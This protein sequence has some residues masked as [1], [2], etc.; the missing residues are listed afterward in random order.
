MR[1]PLAILFA[2]LLAACS[3]GDGDAPPPAGAASAAASE[4]SERSCGEPAQQQY[5]EA[6]AGAKLEARY[7]EL[8]VLILGRAGDGERTFILLDDDWQ[9]YLRQGVRDLLASVARLEGLAPVAGAEGVDAQVR[10][11]VGRT[12]ELAVFLGGGDE[13]L[14]GDRLTEAQQRVLDGRSRLFRLTRAIEELC[15]QPARGR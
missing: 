2:V 4:P 10:E 13:E 11:A 7:A 15:E 6:I 3:G 14:P 1:L 12:R 8:T 9:L 5:L